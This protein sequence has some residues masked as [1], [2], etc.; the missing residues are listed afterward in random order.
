M[1]NNDNQKTY[2]I[3]DEESGLYK[4]RQYAKDFVDGNTGEQVGVKNVLVLYTKYSKMTGTANR[5]VAD[6]SGGKGV[7]ICAGRM[8]NITWK[9]SDSAGLRLYKSDGSALDL[10]VG[11][12]FI[13]CADS[14]SGGVSVK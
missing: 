10:A 13:C 9:R 3:Y 6:M 1:Q 8:I 7:Y 12:S 5:L 2:F 4:I 11:H 14:S